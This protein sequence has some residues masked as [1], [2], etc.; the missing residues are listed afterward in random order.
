MANEGRVMSSDQILKRVW[1]EDYLGDNHLVQV[2]IACL[3]RKLR[4]DNGS[5]IIETRTG[6]GYLI[7]ITE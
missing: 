7:K 3:R 1:G 6:I 2:N 5:R 4:E